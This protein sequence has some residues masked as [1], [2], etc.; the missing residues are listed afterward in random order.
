[1][2]PDAFHLDQREIGET[3]HRGVLLDTLVGVGQNLAADGVTA[4][5][6]AAWAAARRRRER[7][8]RD[9]SAAVV[10]VELLDNEGAVV[11]S[12]L[13]LRGDGGDALRT[14]EVEAG[15]LLENGRL[16]RLRITFPGER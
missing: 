16:Q 2:L 11:R 13:E 12:I 15:P 7:E 10:R 14:F 1:M 8:L 3:G 6:A 5:L 4:L 9:A